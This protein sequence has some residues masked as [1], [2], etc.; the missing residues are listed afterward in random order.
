MGGHIYR[1]ISNA[2]R[3]DASYEER[4]DGPDRGLINAWEVG[5]C[6][7][8]RDPDLVEKVKNG[9]LPDLGLKGGVTKKLKKNPKYGCLW[10]LA[11]WQGLRGDP[12][13]IHL[14]REVEMV[15]SKYNVKVIFTGDMSKYANSQD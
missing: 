10:Y 8:Q 15:C 1:D 2:V 5:R 13:N 11:K 4:F 6:L 14:D 3:V 7:A 12:L 9:E